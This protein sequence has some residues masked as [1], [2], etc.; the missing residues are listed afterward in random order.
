MTA[1]TFRYPRTKAESQQR[2]RDALLRLMKTYG[3][4]PDG[5][6]YQYEDLVEIVLG[7]VDCPRFIA[8]SRDETYYMGY[9][10]ATIED[11]CSTLAS[12]VDGD[13]LNVIV[14]VYDLVEE[15]LLDVSVEVIVKPKGTR[16]RCGKCHTASYYEDPLDEDTKCR[17]CGHGPVLDAATFRKWWQ[18]RQAA[19]R[20]RQ[21][22]AG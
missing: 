10:T 9:P 4:D 11:A 2:R 15:H 16:T 5:P 13:T 18:E 3:M 22:G 12:C 7:S 14:G 20:A 1:T 19:E 21:G 6:D 8:I 17:Y